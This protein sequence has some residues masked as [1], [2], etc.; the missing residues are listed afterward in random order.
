MPKTDPRLLEYARENRKGQ[1]YSEKIIWNLVRDKRI[2]VKFRRQHII[3]NYIMDFYCPELKFCIEIDGDSHINKL[4][5]DKLRD[6]YLQNQKIIVIRL[7]AIEVIEQGNKVEE[8]I[9]ENIK[10]LKRRKESS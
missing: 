9:I 5:Y 7:P 1:T 3:G 8:Q 4:N 2:G 10:E 6:E